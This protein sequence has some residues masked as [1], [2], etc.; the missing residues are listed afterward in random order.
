MSFLHT[1]KPIPSDPQLERLNESIA[2]LKAALEDIP[3]TAAQ[4]I[5]LGQLVLL[6]RT[7]E[8]MRRELLG[9]K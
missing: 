4:K 5:V 3:P 6:Q 2:T 8:H 1:Q 9:V 7:A